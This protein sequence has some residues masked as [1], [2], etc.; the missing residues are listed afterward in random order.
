MDKILYAIAAVI[1]VAVAYFFGTRG[2]GKPE[3][4]P[5]ETVKGEK[6]I[7]KNEAKDAMVDANIPEREADL[8]E[9]KKAT[10]KDKLNKLADM[11]NRENQE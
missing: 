11:V 5:L 10:G 8:D 6:K 9:A 2:K 7:I 1:A 4:H 3:Q